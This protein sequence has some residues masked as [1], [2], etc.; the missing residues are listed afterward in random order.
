[1]LGLAALAFAKVQA[2]LVTL[3]VALAINTAGTAGLGSAFAL[4]TAPTLTFA[5]ALKILIIPLAVLTA[6]LVVI[7]V[8]TVNGQTLLRKPMSR[9]AASGKDWSLLMPA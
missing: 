4:A 1:M 9:S 8:A 3:S 6:G 5:A 2:A 7:A